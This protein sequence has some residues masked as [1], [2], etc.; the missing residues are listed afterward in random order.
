M[1]LPKLNH[2]GSVWHGDLWGKGK[3]IGCFTD[4]F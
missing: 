4:E 2:K 1:N 3:G